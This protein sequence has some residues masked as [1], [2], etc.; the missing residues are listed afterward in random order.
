M[1]SP[2]VLRRYPF[3]SFLDPDQLREIAMIT[4]EV[5]LRKGQILFNTDENADA[6]YLLMTGGIELRY[7]VVDEIDPELRK[8][9]VI[10]VINPGD[11]LGISV[12][13]EPNRYTSTAI[14][15][16]EC[17]LLQIDGLALR[18]LCNQDQRLNCG[19]QGMVARTAMDRLHSTRVQLAAATSPS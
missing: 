4:E 2:E 11:F 10:G 14:A 13:I 19:L 3:F 7:V 5:G 16:G 17:Q 1:I 8:E 12:A 18:A 9:F 15:I 6:C